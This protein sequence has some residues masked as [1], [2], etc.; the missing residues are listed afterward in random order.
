METKNTT[1]LDSKAEKENKKTYS[2]PT[3][4]LKT[5][6]SSAKVLLDHNLITTDD[7]AKIRTMHGTA[8]L[9]YMG[10]DMFEE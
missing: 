10:K 6:A 7:L 4:A 5:L 2:K 9:K 1:I 8:T 3:V